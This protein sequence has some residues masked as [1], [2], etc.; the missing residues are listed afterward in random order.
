MSLALGL[1]ACSLVVT[2]YNNGPQLMMLTWINPHLD[3]NHA[4]ERQALADLEQIQAWHRQHQLPLY[5]QWLQEMQAMAA[6]N[7]QASQVCK[8]FDDMRGSLTPLA[9]QFELPTARLALGL[10]NKQLITLQKR[11]EKD[12]KDWRKDWRLDGSA[13][14]QAEVLTDKGLDNAQ[15]V[16]GRLDASQKALLRQLA[17]SSGFDGAKTM[18]ERLRQ[19]ADSVQVLQQ[20][21][22]KQPPL[23]E[24]RVWVRDW[25]ERSLNTPDETYAAYLKK[26]QSINCEAAAQFHNTTTAEQ[27][28]HAIKVLK[29]YEEDIRALMRSPAK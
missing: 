4:Q 16:Y 7:I 2:G 10:Q 29:G 24:A 18:T 5:A 27:R 26:R 23:S 9:A 15:D 25:F 3:L 17:Q 8:L 1:S 11:F 22:S 21:A 13:Q 28:T 14:A 6:H 19:Q 12:N 20:I